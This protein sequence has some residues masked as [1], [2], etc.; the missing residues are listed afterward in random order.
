M[1]RNYLRAPRG[2]G[3]STWTYWTLINSE[4]F[5][6]LFVTQ[7]GSTS[8]AATMLTLDTERHIAKGNTHDV[9]LLR[10]CV[11]VVNCRVH[12]VEKDLKELKGYHN[13]LGRSVEEFIK[14]E[15]SGTR[16]GKM[17]KKKIHRKIQRK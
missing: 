3:Q 13:D 16:S 7:I 1:L 11:R 6:N 8:V 5:L 9:S 14:R 4:L 15:N 17:L 2:V 12:Q 10:Q